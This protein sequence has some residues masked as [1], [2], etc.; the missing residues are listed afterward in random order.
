V[1]FADVG[2]IIHEKYLT[3]HH[4]GNVEYRR[5]FFR[6]EDNGTI[7]WANAVYARHQESELLPIFK[8]RGWAY[9]REVRLIVRLKKGAKKRS[10]QK[11]AVVFD[12]PFAKLEDDILKFKSPKTE[13]RCWR[14]PLWRGPWYD[15]KVECEP[16]LVK[17]GH[18][19]VTLANATPSD[20][21]EEI[22]DNR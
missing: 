8:K 21:S 5:K 12:G 11:I 19:S 18:V 20:Y 10:F 9:E 14:F 7:D 4:S 1:C 17:G 3:T 16:I 13:E 6:V 15:S 2:Y 22:R